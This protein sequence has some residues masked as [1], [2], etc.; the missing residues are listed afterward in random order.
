MQGLLPGRC[1]IAKPPFLP[2]TRC[3]RGSGYVF[4]VFPRLTPWAKELPS[5]NGT[6]NS[7]EPSNAGFNFT[8]HRRISI[9]R[10]SNFNCR[11]Q[12]SLPAHRRAMLTFPQRSRY[13]SLRTSHFVPRTS[14]GAAANFPIVNSQS[15]IVNPVVGL[16]SLGGTPDSLRPAGAGNFQICQ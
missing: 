11:R 8:R 9:L 7:T 12:I 3:A 14:I 13:P 2:P 4:L 10:R 15:Q 6:P 16:P 5:L 1:S